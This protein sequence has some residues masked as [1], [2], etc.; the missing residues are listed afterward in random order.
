MEVKIGNVIWQNNYQ[1]P[2]GIT[3]NRSVTDYLSP[4]SI[5][6]RNMPAPD[7]RPV[8]FKQPDTTPSTEVKGQFIN[9]R[10]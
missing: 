3:G 10:V 9:V 4:Q 1:N 8:D 6:S 5:E 2:E 7:A